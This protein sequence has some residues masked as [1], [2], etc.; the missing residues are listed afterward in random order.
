MNGS[1]V[2]NELMTGWNWARACLGHWEETY[3]GRNVTRDGMAIRH[4]TN[5]RTKESPD[6]NHSHTHA[7][8]DEA[9][10]LLNE[11]NKYIMSHFTCTRARAVQARKIVSPE[12]NGNPWTHKHS[13]HRIDTNSFVMELHSFEW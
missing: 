1:K 2:C 11:S 4:E 3:D 12:N 9:T 7:G 5:A 10:R 6:L 8:L 13:L